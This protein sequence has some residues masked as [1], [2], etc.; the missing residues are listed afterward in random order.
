[1]KKENSFLLLLMTTFFANAGTFSVIIKDDNKYDIY[2]KGKTNISEWNDVSEPYECVKRYDK[3]N[4][5]LNAEFTQ[6][7][8][9]KQDQEREITKYYI[10]DNIHTTTSEKENQ[11]VDVEVS[12]V[13][14]GTYLAKSCKEV[15]NTG[16]SV[17][18]GL[19]SVY[20]NGTETSVNCDMTTDGGGW[21]IVADQNLYVEGYPST[22]GLPNANPNSVQSTKLKY[23]PYFSEYAL[24]S[25]IDL[26]GVSYSSSSDG[27]LEPKFIKYDTGS[28]GEVNLN[29]IDFVLYKTDYQSGRAS[30]NYVM[31]NGTAWGDSDTRDH[32]YAYYWF[33][34]NSST[35][36]FWGQSEIWGE[37]FTSSIYRIASTVTGYATTGTCGP[38]WAANDCRL[39][40]TAWQQ[41]S[42]VK[43]KA[44]FLVR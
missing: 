26:N 5:Y 33:N 14:I 37:I 18:D 12:S 7:E 13:E 44:L 40:L 17:G 31:Y 29:M 28:F 32:Y 11:T 35:Y 20:I 25:V 1:M 22:I 41:R 15:L 27:S 6:I 3:S 38:A 24:K 42:T 34:K 10:K 36:N 9:C 30:N 43:Q 4:F 39:A 23:W 16:G 8:D 19:Y 21:T 2:E